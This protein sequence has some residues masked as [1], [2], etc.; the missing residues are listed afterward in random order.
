MDVPGIVEV[1]NIKCN[2]KSIKSQYSHYDKSVPAWPSGHGGFIE[3]HS[4]IPRIPQKTQ[5][6]LIQ[7]REG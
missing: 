4:L 5:V 6:E 2:Q 1:T 7:P 3:R